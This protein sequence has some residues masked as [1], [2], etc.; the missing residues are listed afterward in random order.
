MLE[1]STVFFFFFPCF[2]SHCSHK[3]INI[4]WQLELAQLDKTA[5]SH[6]PQSF[7]CTLTPLQYHH[8]VT[9]MP[10][11]VIIP[12]NIDDPSNGATSYDSPRPPRQVE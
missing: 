1:I 4:D 8:Q 12:N 2:P 10:S 9:F 6:F 5:S 3:K 11:S 7:S